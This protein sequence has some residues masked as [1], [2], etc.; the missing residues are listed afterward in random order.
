MPQVSFSAD[1]KPLFRS[2]DIS[3]MKP[4]GVE[5]DCGFERYW[6]K[7][8]ALFGVTRDPKWHR[9]SRDRGCPTA[10]VYDCA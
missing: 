8:S 2:I 10:Q 5:L 3:H 9:K 7:T 6:R 1:I 4:F